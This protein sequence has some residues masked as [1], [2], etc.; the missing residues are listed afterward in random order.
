MAHLLRLALIL[1]CLL[2]FNAA[3]AAFPP[4]P[5]G[6]TGSSP[7]S[8]PGTAS[9]S[10]PGGVC[11]ALNA[12][13]IYPDWSINH[14]PYSGWP[15][16]GCEAKD[17]SSAV[18]STVEI[19]ATGLSCPAGAE[20]SG[21]SCGC[22]AGL[23]EWMGQCKTPCA[24]GEVRDGTGVCRI[25]CPEGQH[26]E[27]GACVPDN[28]KPNETRVNGVCVPEP[29][30]PAGQTRVNGKCK[31]S[32]CPKAGTLAGEYMVSST[33]PTAMCEGGCTVSIASFLTAYQGGKAVSVV[34]IGYYT[35]GVCTAPP[36]SP[37]PDGGGGGGTGGGTGGT[38]G[39]TGGT[40]GTGGSGGGTGGGTGGS[41][42]NDTPPEKC[43]NGDCTGT[44]GDG[45]PGEDPPSDGECPPGT[46]KSG[47]KCYPNSPPDQPP[48]NDGACPPGYAKVGDK[49]VPYKPDE[50]EEDKPS[51][52]GGACGGFVCEGDA[53]QCAIA[54]EQH[55]RACK[56]FD[57]ES[58]ES[59]LYN[60]NKGKEGKQTNDLPGNDT[61]SLLGRINMND[62]FGGGGQCTNDVTVVVMG[63]SIT[64]PF[65][66][67]CPAI[68]VIGNIM[69]AVSLLLAARILTR[70]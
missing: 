48:N 63:Q 34:G 42:N 59:K 10:S 32:G 14:V 15:Y 51:T 27:G 49:C 1:V 37:D 22:F 61:V 69:V 62:L 33:T 25:P 41:G 16:G 46:Y 29:P 54:R 38:G 55:Q 47:G 30:C 4:T 35:G 28:C 66:K 58:A 68:A 39:G 13:R 36:T 21:G 56:L 19:T 2:G 17:G 40:G 24:A 12:A 26:E 44:G 43:P 64:L 9:A 20:L 11:V 52:F 50:D 3:H 65:T 18:V 31:D 70:G 7:Y 67:I 6:Y 60:D 53:I 23:T 45:P 5:S 57:D 8:S